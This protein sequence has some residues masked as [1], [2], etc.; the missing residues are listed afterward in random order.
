MIS[1][2]T[3]ILIGIG[4]CYLGSLIHD[5]VKFYNFKTWLRSRNIDIDS[6]DEPNMRA[7]MTA[8]NLRK[9]PNVTIDLV[10]DNPE[11]KEVE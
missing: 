4:I 10:A 8:Y 9:V 1:I 7:A 3:G 5:V 6:L 2:F 11:S